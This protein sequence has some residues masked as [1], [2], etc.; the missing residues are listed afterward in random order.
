MHPPHDL[1][2][3]S[4]NVEEALNGQ[5]HASLVRSYLFWLGLTACVC[6]LS[7]LS[8]NAYLFHYAQQSTLDRL[9]KRL[10]EQVEN[11][12]LFVFSM[13]QNF[14][15]ISSVF[16]YKAFLDS[17]SVRAK[18]SS[19]LSTKKQFYGP[20]TFKNHFE[21]CLL[22]GNGSVEH[23]SE[24]ALQS[25]AGLFSY[26]PKILPDFLTAFPQVNRVSYI[27][28]DFKL[29]CPWNSFPPR[30]NPEWLQDNQA[31][32]GA[33]SVPLLYDNPTWLPLS[34]KR[35][36]KIWSVQ[37]V[38]PSFE[39][40]ALTGFF[41]FTLPQAFFV[42]YLKKFEISFGKIL[43]IDQENASIASMEA[44]H[45]PESNVLFLKK[46]I[47]KILLDKDNGTS[48]F[49]EPGKL[50][51]QYVGGV[52]GFWT[53]V[54]PFKKA[55]WKLIFIGSLWDVAKNDFQ[56]TLSDSLM[57][58]LTAF[59]MLFLSYILVK[60]YFV[61]PSFQLIR[62]LE[63]ERQ[64]IDSDLKHLPLAWR[65]WGRLISSIFGENRQLV[66]EL[67][68]RV[69]ERTQA[70]KNTLSNLQ[71]SQHQII[72]QEKLASLGTLAA[73]IA[74]EIKNPLNFVLNFAKI[75]KDLL[76]ELEKQEDFS[77]SSLPIE[78]LEENLGKIIEHAD[79][80]DHIVKS[81]LLHARSNPA[82]LEE[83]DMNRFV[84]EYA[85]L[86]YQSF[87]A[88]HRD[89]PIQFE[90]KLDDNVGKLHIYPQEMGRVL[91][92][93]LNNAFETV[94]ARFEKENK[95]SQPPTYQ[96]TVLIQTKDTQDTLI[97]M[98]HDNGEGIPASIL[99]KIFDP[100]FTTK[101]PGKGTGLG[102]SISY[103]CIQH[104]R[105]SLEVESQEGEGSWFLIRIPKDLAAGS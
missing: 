97:I 19:F 9:E 2:H 20:I 47:P 82:V 94:T 77:K 13:T 35:V 51:F 44:G 29:I 72:A 87:F 28:N 22:Y 73:G 74:H 61:S 39:K 43:L 54:I 93:L 12:D 14:S 46:K 53:C 83:I 66:A 95:N 3:A 79:R 75:S 50:K 48:F 62:H 89:I 65:H 91:L 59:F 92:N 17:E 102:L 18:L 24:R 90:K 38:T 21:G 78:T 1:A 70:L 27:S 10:Q 63:N 36:G 55:P 69:Q 56:V 6:V 81:M 7:S 23:L 99:K 100:F 68:T 64:G 60:R 41:S 57:I 37:Y 71:A 42:D 34:Y 84:I 67:E 76:G 16:R 40:K 31:L 5:V 11:L 32:A 33:L 105:G 25:A 30:I 86:C 96:P 45:P 8:F 4:E 88:Q 104:H 85:D 58:F 26:I 49:S 98:V 101:P 80:A 15:N 103:D 52:N